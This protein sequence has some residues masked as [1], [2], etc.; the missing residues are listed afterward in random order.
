MKILRSLA[1]AFSSYSKIPIPQFEWKAEDMR[2]I[3]SFFPCIGLV[4]GFLEV[5][6]FRITSQL[7]IAEIARVIVAAL[8]PLI[9]TGGY[10]IDGFMDTSDA[11]SSYRDREKR[12][13]ILKD[14]HVGAFA[15]IRL[16]TAA[17]LFTAAMAEIKSLEAVY[18]LA[19]GF[20][21]SRCLSALGV[22]HFQS[23]NH[24]GSLFYTASN[25][26]RAV[27]TLTVGIIAIASIVLMIIV[28]P[29]VG[30]LA[31]VGG[32]GSFIYYRIMSYKKFGGI[33]GDL[34]GY[35]V[36]IAEVVMAIM[37]AIGELICR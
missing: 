10:H 21:F 8:I 25:S 24:K 16:I 30:I 18:V 23:A 6:W 22:L 9:I 1:I 13:E 37:I 19:L 2:Y 5:I 7:G 36:V 35:F 29:L 27:N 28:K 12:L 33:T 31:V 17:A 32:A 11:I 34:A 20:I 14:S 15:V 26:D 3:M 4:I